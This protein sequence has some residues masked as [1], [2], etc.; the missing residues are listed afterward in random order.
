MLCGL[1][2]LAAMGLAGTKRTT[3]GMAARPRKALPCPNALN[4]TRTEQQILDRLFVYA[5]QIKQWLNV[6]QPGSI[7][8]QNI[9][10]RWNGLVVKLDPDAPDEGGQFTGCINIQLDGYPSTGEFVLPQELLESRLVARLVHELAH[11]AAGLGTGHYK[12]FADANNY[13]AHIAADQ[14]GLPVAL[15]CGG[16]CQHSGICTRQWCQKCTWVKPNPRGNN[17]IPVLPTECGS[18]MPGP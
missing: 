4:P 10:Q 8:T 2:L 14:L 13:L 7:Y 3:E 5:H 18:Y 16:G 12:R 17:L 15:T 11:A 6:N 1:A 9:N